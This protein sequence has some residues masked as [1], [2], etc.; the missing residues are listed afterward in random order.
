MA[1]NNFLH[2]PEDKIY[3]QKFYP[4][5]QC[6]SSKGWY[7]VV[8]PWRAE[9]I[10][11]FLVQHLSSSLESEAE[12]W[13]SAAERLRRMESIRRQSPKNKELMKRVF[14]DAFCATTVGNRFQIRRF[15]RP[16]DSGLRK[17]VSLSGMF[18]EEALA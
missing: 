12:A 1:R 11:P 2:R 17:N 8:N 16:E 14:G 9:P 13:Q 5:S 4:R 7:Q 10:T 3:V 6:I 15:R 18:S